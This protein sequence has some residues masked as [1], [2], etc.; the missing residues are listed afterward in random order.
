MRKGRKSEKTVMALASVAVIAAGVTALNASMTFAEQQ[1]ETREL[2]EL[3]DTAVEGDV[4]GEVE[5]YYTTETIWNEKT[6]EVIYYSDEIP[7]GHISCEAAIDKAYEHVKKIA[8]VDVSDTDITVCMYEEYQDEECTIVSG[9][10]YDVYFEYGD[11]ITD[12]SYVVSLEAVTG[13]IDEYI[14]YCNEAVTEQECIENRIIIDG[15]RESQLGYGIED[16]ENN[17]DG[18]DELWGMEMAKAEPEYIAIAESFVENML[19]MEDVEFSEGYSTSTGL[20][21]DGERYYYGVYCK[22]INGDIIRVEIDQMTKTVAG[23]CIDV[24][25]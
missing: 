16:Y 14:Y 6:V 4:S 19:N 9:R 1:T 5:E 11:G 8:G 24:M 12:D 22:T 25:Y 15:Y 18:V 3:V 21:G 17:P 20:R 2:Q 23:Y 13:K 10:K 7:D